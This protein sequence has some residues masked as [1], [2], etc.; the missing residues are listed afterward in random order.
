MILKPEEKGTLTLFTFPYIKWKAFACWWQNTENFLLA[1]IYYQRNCSKLG[2]DHVFTYQ[3]HHSKKRWGEG[4]I[5]RDLH[6]QCFLHVQ[7]SWEVL[8]IH[9]PRLT[10]SPIML[11]FKM[12]HVLVLG[13]QQSPVHPHFPH[14]N[15]KY[16]VFFLLCSCLAYQTKNHRWPWFWAWINKWA[17]TQ[18]QG[19]LRVLQTRAITSK[20]EQ[21]DRIQHWVLPKDISHGVHRKRSYYLGIKM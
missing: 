3:L 6:F 17:L 12:L 8:K 15:K 4:G 10:I 1:M 14:T 16:L 9:S 5:T 2:C 18:N 20:L 21:E 19:G 13:C 7:C 11:S